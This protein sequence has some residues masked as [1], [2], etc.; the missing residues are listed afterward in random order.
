MEF[1]D[2]INEMKSE[3]LLQLKPQMMK[4]TIVVYVDDERPLKVSDQR[5]VA[6][7][8]NLYLNSTNNPTSFFQLGEVEQNDNIRYFLA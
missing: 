1:Q 7:N 8:K 4:Y 2:H 3:L 5:K 6:Y